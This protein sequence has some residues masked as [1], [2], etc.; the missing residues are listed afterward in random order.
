MEYDYE[1]LKAKKLEVAAVAEQGLAGYAADKKLIAKLVVE[2]F[3]NV[4]A[5]ESP[6]Y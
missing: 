2:V 3:A 4:S 1:A 5:P 6:Q